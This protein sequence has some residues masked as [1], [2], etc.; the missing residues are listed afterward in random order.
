M[1]VGK[2]RDIRAGRTSKSKPRKNRNSIIIPTERN[3][4]PVLKTDTEQADSRTHECGGPEWNT[5]NYI[6]LLEREVLQPP[7]Q[8]S[9][10]RYCKKVHETTMDIQQQWLRVYTVR[11]FQ[12]KNRRHQMGFVAA[13]RHFI[14]RL[15]IRQKFTGNQ[16]TSIYHRTYRCTFAQ[17]VVRTIKEIEVSFDLVWLG[18]H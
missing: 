16:P 8:I 14:Y 5:N 15:N 11:I 1:V 2:A 17:Y 6:L 18:S 4:L 13:T 12:E 9:R 7:G 3:L 10:M